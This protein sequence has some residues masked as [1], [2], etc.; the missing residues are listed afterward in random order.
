MTNE[1]GFFVSIKLCVKC[2]NNRYFNY[3][4]VFDP[5]VRVHILFN[6]YIVQH[7]FYKTEYNTYIHIYKKLINIK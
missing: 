7:L 4:L 5:H 3:K 6:F 2:K 1:W